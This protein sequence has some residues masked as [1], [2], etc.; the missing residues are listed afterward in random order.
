MSTRFA[1]LVVL[2]CFGFGLS[3]QVIDRKD[4]ITG[5]YQALPPL[6]RFLE[7]LDELR[8]IFG[9]P[10]EEQEAAK[11]TWITKDRLIFDDLLKL[12]KRSPPIPLTFVANASD[13]FRVNKSHAPRLMRSPTDGDARAP[14]GDIF[15]NLDLLNSPNSN[16]DPSQVAR[17]LL[18]EWCRKLES[19][20][21]IEDCDH[22][23]SKIMKVTEKYFKTHRDEESHLRLHTINLPLAR[24]RSHIEDHPEQF[25]TDPTSWVFLENPISIVNLTPLMRGKLNGFY[26][27]LSTLTQLGQDILNL[28]MNQVTPQ[29]NQMLPQLAANMGKFLAEK[30]LTPGSALPF[31]TF[32]EIAPGPRGSPRQF[33]AFSPKRF[34]VQE[35]SEG[36]FSVS[37]GGSVQRNSISEW[38]FPVLLKGEKISS[39]DFD[40]NLDKQ[41]GTTTGFDLP[42][43]LQF[44]YDAKLQN[45]RFNDKQVH[46]ELEPRFRFDTPAKVKRVVRN[47]DQLVALSSTIPA[48]ALAEL[49]DADG[50]KIHSLYYVLN[51]G[52]RRINIPA[53]AEFLRDQSILVKSQGPFSEFNGLSFVDSILVNNETLVPLDRIITAQV[54]S[55]APPTP[56]IE[57]DENSIALLG[58]DGPGS[59]PNLNRAPDPRLRK[60]PMIVILPASAREP[61]RRLLKKDSHFFSDGKD[62][63]NEQKGIAF[64]SDFFGMT[65]ETKGYPPSFIRQIRMSVRRQV[66]LGDPKDTAK[67]FMVPTEGKTLLPFTIDIDHAQTAAKTEI[68][69]FD[70][71]EIESLGAN[72]FRLKSQIVYKTSSQ[73]EEAMAQKSRATLSRPHES[74]NLINIISMDILFGD[75]TLSHFDFGPTKEEAQSGNCN[76]ILKSSFGSTSFRSH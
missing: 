69:V 65:F 67:T 31:M 1:F 33:F 15:V 68:L 41:Q 61:M 50:P 13:D 54:G 72:R 21:S 57:V 74:P 25:K 49:S 18:H 20:F 6:L 3:A 26:H 75:G 66:T 62:G 35:I 38:Q 48:S 24:I 16:L 73:F 19:R 8:T 42:I 34:S 28:L 76:I 43:R 70:G 14:H 10:T 27:S 53:E 30:G 59:E 12:A 46:T 9:D 63:P 52:S 64:F 22:T 40:L 51:N 56:P 44:I 36:L 60:L 2:S 32:G 11:N 29:F 23:I 4:L 47:S 7:P 39:F 5:T 55:P 17:I 37:I 45:I 71:N 58:I